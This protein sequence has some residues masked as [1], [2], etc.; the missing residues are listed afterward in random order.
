MTAHQSERIAAL[1]AIRERHPGTSGK[2][3]RECLLDALHTLGSVLTFEASRLLGC[4]HPPARAMELR[5]NGT[6]IITT[7]E[8]VTTEDGEVHQVGRYSLVREA[9]R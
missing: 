4:Y 3:Q 9:Q 2:A 7:M 5:R 1:L 8:P 6:N